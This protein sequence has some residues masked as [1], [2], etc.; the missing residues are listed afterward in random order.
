MRSAAGFVIE[1]LGS[2]KD[3]LPFSV[4][5]EEMARLVVEGFDIFSRR[6]D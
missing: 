3:E 4:Y 6:D 5:V 2:R 1:S